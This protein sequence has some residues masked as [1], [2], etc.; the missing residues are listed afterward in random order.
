MSN[1]FNSSLFSSQNDFFYSY[2]DY[3]NQIPI[4]KTRGYTVGPTGPEGPQGPTGAY[5]YTGAKGHV[6][7]KGPQGTKG[8]YQE[9][10]VISYDT[11]TFSGKNNIF[12]MELKPINPS[13]SGTNTITVL[14]TGKD[15][16]TNINQYGLFQIPANAQVVVS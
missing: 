6:G 8:T 10:F 5:G 2:S 4:C 12:S 9:E 11:I 14:V 3:I 16:L 1:L 15:F 13:L 7:P